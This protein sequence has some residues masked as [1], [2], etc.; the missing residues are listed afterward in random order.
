MKPPR[1][2][3]PYKLWPPAPTPA[4]ALAGLVEGQSARLGGR[5]FSAKA[6]LDWLQ[7]IESDEGHELDAFLHKAMGF[8]A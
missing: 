6:M 4:D 8:G 7:G 1:P 2:D 3:W 5:E